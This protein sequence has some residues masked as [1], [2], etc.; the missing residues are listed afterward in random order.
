MDSVLNR[1]VR[2]NVEREIRLHQANLCERH[3]NISSKDDQLMA[4]RRGVLFF[5]IVF[6]HC[7]S[8]N[9]ELDLSQVNLLHVLDHHCLQMEGTS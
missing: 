5:L 7:R 1:F 3:R 8:K 6:G 9:N 4:K 2:Y